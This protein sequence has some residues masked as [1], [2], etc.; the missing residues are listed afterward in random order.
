M[1]LLR[2]AEAEYQTVGFM[3]TI[4]CIITDGGLIINLFFNKKI[5]K[6]ILKSRK[7]FIRALRR[8]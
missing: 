3:S 4:N 6:T 7:P 1:D 5:L 8:K 2:Y